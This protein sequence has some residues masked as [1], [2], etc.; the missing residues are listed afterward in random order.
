M[1]W[2]ALAAGARDA[3]G[4]TDKTPRTVKMGGIIALALRNVDFPK[5][6]GRAD[7]VFRDDEMPMTLSTVLCFHDD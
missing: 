1:P 2:S 5:S 7:F 6:R 4:L 3:K